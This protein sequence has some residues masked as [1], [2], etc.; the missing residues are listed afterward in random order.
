VIDMLEEMK[1]R[2]APIQIERIDRK[3]RKP[4]GV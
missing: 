3:T 1:R 2:G 4:D